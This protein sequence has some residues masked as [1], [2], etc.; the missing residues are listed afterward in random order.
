MYL[1]WAMLHSYTLIY[2]YFFD[3]SRYNYTFSYK[4]ST[5]TAIKDKVSAKETLV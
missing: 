1:Y 2:Q 4:Q 5:E 3:W